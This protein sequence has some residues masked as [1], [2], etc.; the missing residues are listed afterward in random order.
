MS[1]MEIFHGYFVPCD[2]DIEPSDTDEFYD[3]EQEQ[4]AYFVKVRDVVYKFWRSELKLEPYG[5][6]VVVPPSY[7]CQLFLMWYNGG[8]GI[9][10]VAASAIESW[11]DGVR[12]ND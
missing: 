2:L 8:A 10:E 1:E 12:S 7:R 6:T 11:L 4:N 5:F 3:F 9:H